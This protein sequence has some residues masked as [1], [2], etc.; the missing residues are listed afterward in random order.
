M[1]GATFASTPWSLDLCIF[2]AGMSDH[3]SSLAQC[4]YCFVGDD[5]R[6]ELEIQLHPQQ[7]VSMLLG[8]RVLGEMS[9]V[10]YAHWLT[11]TSFAVFCVPWLG[12]TLM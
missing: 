12:V 2:P 1:C 5:T 10:F 3:P 6:S 11:S 9:R 7:A 4:V 8:Q